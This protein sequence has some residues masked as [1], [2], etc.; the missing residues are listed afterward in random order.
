MTPL[1]A[2][3]SSSACAV[4]SGIT[5]TASWYR[6]S[7]RYPSTA[8]SA[9]HRQVPPLRSSPWLG[10]LLR[11]PPLMP[12][13]CRRGP[14]FRHAFTNLSRSARPVSIPPIRRSPQATCRP[15]ASATDTIPEHTF[16]PPS[17][18]RSM[19]RRAAALRG[20]ES[21][22]EA[23][24][25]SFPRPGAA[26]RIRPA[27]TATTA[28]RGGFTP[29]CSTRTP[30]VASSCLTKLG[31]QLCVA[32]VRSLGSERARRMGRAEARRILK[33]CR[34]HP[35]AKASTSGKTRGAFHLRTCR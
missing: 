24:Q 5:R 4:P 30:L 12:R 28:R 9:F 25:P 1:V 10:A 13:L 31:N 11:G 32:T 23:H 33:G 18:P 15:P 8:R 6:A 2:L 19:R 16:E 7:P 20:G 3:P 22:C 14:S 17:P 21:S 26:E 34:P 29:T 35:L 27:P